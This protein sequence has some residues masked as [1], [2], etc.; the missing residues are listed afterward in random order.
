MAGIFPACCSLQGL[1][2]L[3]VQHFGIGLGFERLD[4]FG[5]YGSG[6]RG[7]GSLKLSQRPGFHLHRNVA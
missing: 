5:D 2:C 4:G 1:G 7:H 3:G 6:F